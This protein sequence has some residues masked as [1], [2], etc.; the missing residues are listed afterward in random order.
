[1][2]SCF[3]TICRSSQCILYFNY[4]PHE[5]VIFNKRDCPWIKENAKQLILEENGQ[6]K[7]I[8]DMLEN[9]DTKIFDKVK[10]LE[11]KLISKIESNKQK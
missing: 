10:C 1:M 2:P 3:L 7:C 4:V 8:K 6:M 5:T 11:D 9:K